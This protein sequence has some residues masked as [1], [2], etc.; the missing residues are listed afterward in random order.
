VGAFATLGRTGVRE[1]GNP[2]GVG[3]SVTWPLGEIAGFRLEGSRSRSSRRWTA[4]T[5]EAYWPLYT[6]CREETVEN[7]VRS[8]QVAALLIVA[9]F[10]RSS[11]RVEGNFGISRMHLSHEI[12]AIESGRPLNPHS[13][14]EGAFSASY[15]A[16]LVRAGL[17][18]EQL[19]ARLEWRHAGMRGNV[20]PCPADGPCPP[21]WDDFGVDELR[22]GA[23]WRF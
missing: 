21:Q 17:G 10:R 16:G 15:G 18:A 19:D 5:C 1:L 8:T 14:Q 6:D 11:W 23:S 7:G 3:L 4:T 2:A 22:L 12:A 9:P 13:D 20:S